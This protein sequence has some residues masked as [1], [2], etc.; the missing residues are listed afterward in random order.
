MTREE[1]YEAKAAKIS[2]QCEDRIEKA[3]IKEAR[4]KEIARE[5]ALDAEADDLAFGM[6]PSEAEKQ[7]ELFFKG[8]SEQAEEACMDK[9]DKILDEAERKAAKLDEKYNS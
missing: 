7:R 3:F 1:K 2:E 9:I 8:A 4:D 5:E 6:S